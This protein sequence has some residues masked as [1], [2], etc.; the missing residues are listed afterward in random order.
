MEN[1]NNEVKDIDFINAVPQKRISKL[2]I[3]ALILSFAPVWGGPI[4]GIVF[5]LPYGIILFFLG[6]F[7]F[8]IMGIILG[9]V[10]LCSRKK[11][12]KLS[13]RIFSVIAILFPLI[14]YCIVFL[15]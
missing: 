12:P 5:W 13:A 10:I 15:R 7:G 3:I 11:Y 6:V 14:R 9:A 4:W 2:P 8:P 1:Q